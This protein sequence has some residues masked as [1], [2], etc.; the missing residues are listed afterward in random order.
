MTAHCSSSINLYIDHGLLHIDYKPHTGYFVLH[1]G[2]N[3]I[4][5]FTGHGLLRGGQ[6]TFRF[7]L[8]R[9]RDK[10]SIDFDTLDLIL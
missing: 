2:P 8:G 1:S 7:D 5:L 3:T 10:G 9:G 6:K 4:R